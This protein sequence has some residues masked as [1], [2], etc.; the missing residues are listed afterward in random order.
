MIVN[1]IISVK[2][3]TLVE[4][5]EKVA[6]KE[7]DA[8]VHLIN[9]HHYGVGTELEALLKWFGINAAPGCKCKQHVYEMN[10]K[11]VVWC[12]QNTDTIVG[13]L[14]EEADRAGYPF[15]ETGAKILIN[16]AISKAEKKI[17]KEQTMMT[18]KL[19]VEIDTD[20]VYDALMRTKPREGKVTAATAEP[21]RP[22][23]P[24]QGTS[25][26][27]QKCTPGMSPPP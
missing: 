2:A 4:A 27:P 21:P 24:T 20:D 6:P 8:H 12:K 11:G 3:V 10:N 25:G 16:R 22:T 13:W 5:A 26:R 18:V 23:N 15:T 7:G 14:R 1:Y 9:L 19:V 17:K